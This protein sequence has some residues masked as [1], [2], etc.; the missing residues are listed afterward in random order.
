MHLLYNNNQG[1]ILWK[2]L[3]TVRE[4]V[5]LSGYSERSIRQFIKDGK[6]EIVRTA[7]D[8]VRI[9]EKIT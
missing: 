7:T 1:G 9:K 6:L 8:R 5:N 4:V 3:Y 2:K